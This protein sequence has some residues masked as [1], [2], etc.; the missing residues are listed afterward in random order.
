M[1]FIIDEDYTV[2]MKYWGKSQSMSYD[3]PTEFHLAQLHVKG[4]RGNLRSSPPLIHDVGWK[5][6]SII[7]AY[8]PETKLVPTSVPEAKVAPSCTGI[9]DN[10]TGNEFLQ[11][12]DKVFGYNNYTIMTKRTRELQVQFEDQHL[13]KLKQAWSFHD[14]SIQY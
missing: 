7:E 4:R 9:Q 11:V 12:L 10:L 8:S 13:Q 3:R 2:V 6:I 1:I 5:P 14:S